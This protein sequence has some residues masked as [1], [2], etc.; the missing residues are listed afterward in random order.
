MPFNAYAAFDATSMKQLMQERL[1]QG[2][3]FTDQLFEGS[4]FNSLLDIIAYS[5][6]VLL[7]YLNKTGS[8]TL[9]TQAQLYENMNRI[10]KSLNY[11]PVGYQ[12]S[13]LNFNA[14]APT[15]LAQDIYT[16]PRYSY[17]TVDGIN[18]SFTKDT[19]F[20]KFSDA[21]E[22]LQ[23][24][25][26]SSILYQGLFIEYPIYSAT[27][28]PFER[29]SIAAVNPDN[30]N[31]IIDHT[32]IDVYVLDETNK[33]VQWTRVDSL[34]LQDPSTKAYECRL[35]E[36]QR[37]EIKFGNNITG[38]QIGIGNRVAVYY[39]RS[40]GATGEVGPN[41]LDGNRLF[42]YNTNQFNT[43]FS[44]TRSINQKYLSQSQASSLTFTNTNA[45]TQF[46]NLESAENMRANAANTFK[47]QF[48]LITTDDFELYIKNN[49]GNIIND[50]KV[51]NNWEYLSEHVR[52]L[53]NIGLKSPNTDS[54]VLFNQV[55]FADSCDFNNLYI[56]LV[57]KLQKYSST[58]TS[59]NFLATGLKDY[60]LQG[61]QN[62]KMATAEAVLMDPVYMAVGIGAASN[63][64]IGNKLL[65]PD[66]I[67]Q[68]RLIVGR[69]PN[70]RFSANEIKRQIVSILTD[71]FSP[72]NVKL[73]QKIDLD[74]LTTSILNIEGVTELNT[75]RTVNE[76]EISRT[77][78]SLLVFNPIYNDP[79]EDIEII[80]Q[81]YILPYFKIPF[82]YNAE[83][84]LTQIE[85]VT[86]N[87]QG[88][89]I[90][91]Y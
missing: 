77:G 19:T 51:V 2:G 62:I 48:R 88:A 18:Y 7:F 72:K 54:R 27:G 10:V 87:V 30:S 64:E 36:N 69:S 57:P 76:Q 58:Q 43:I 73:G 44:D 6:N 21:E 35:N 17:F 42:L 15:T 3:V 74:Y 80:S 47:T 81:S 41:T 50:V 65:T 38:K 67:N 66:L 61:V 84:L 9:Y 60:I 90:R 49:Y 5:Y 91:E 24:L 20:T 25:M 12:S 11:N 55:T 8:E 22:L 26:D 75:V 82:L 89:S 63:S 39:L 46:S 59:S 28:Q 31:E 83:T 14:T 68:T 78:I 29:F 33:W 40:N 45:S 85:I 70:S 13:V 34:Y 86:P 56:Y 71:Y 4:N 52:Y 23:N 1:T 16:I 32:N 79:G 37:Y 53:Y